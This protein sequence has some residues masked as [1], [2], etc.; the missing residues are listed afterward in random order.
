ME[1][2]ITQTDSLEIYNLT[3][4]DLKDVEYIYGKN[5]HN[6]RQPSKL[7]LINT[8][9]QIAIAKHGSLENIE[10]SKHIKQEKSERRAVKKNI[11]KEQRKISLVNRL[12]EA[13]LELRQDSKLCEKYINGT[14]DSYY[15][16]EWVVKRMCQMKYLFE[17][18]NM[19]NFIQKAKRDIFPDCSIMEQAEMYAMENHEYPV[20]F[21]WMDRAKLTE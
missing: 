14:L 2:R 17:Y 4:K 16:E 3:L 10:I 8:I 15:T 9:Q 11:S 12:L 20:I 19:D 1:S 5:S 18:R 7:Y 13:G 21:P 6:R